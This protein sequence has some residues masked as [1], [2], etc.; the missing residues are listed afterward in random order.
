MWGLFFC[1]KSYLKDNTG[2]SRGKA[3]LPII[4]IKISEI[5]LLPISIVVGW[6]LCMLL[7]SSL[8]S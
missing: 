6:I 4:G 8:E 5:G 7:Q 3:L 2:A 1:E